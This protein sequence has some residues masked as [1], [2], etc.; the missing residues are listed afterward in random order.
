MAQRVQVA[1]DCHDP[2]RLAE[3]WA[4]VLGYALMNPPDGYASWAE[5][6]RAQAEQPG[7][8][9]TKIVDPQGREPTLL[10]HRVPEAKVVKNRVHLDVRAPDDEPGD[11]QQQVDAFIERVV[12]LGARKVRDVTDDAGYFAVM[13]DPEGNEFCIG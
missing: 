1:V 10:F 8:A 6:S 12:A 9:W 3:F 2:D 11:R 7:E 5:H 13:Q 4:A